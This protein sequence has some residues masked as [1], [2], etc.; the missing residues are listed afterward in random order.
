MDEEYDVIICGTGLKECILSG[1]LSVEGKKVLHVDRNRYYGGDGASLNITTLWQK[2]KPNEQPPKEYGANR[3]WNVDLVPKF[4]MASG[5][6]VK[7]LLHTGV[8]RYLEWK[9]V[10]GTY[11]YQYQEA[12]FFSN[13]KF[14]HKVPN[15]PQDALKSSLLGLMEKPRV[16]QFLN[17]VLGWNDND[18]KTWKGVDPQ[19]H[20]MAQVFDSYSLE[21]RT[22]TFLGHGVALYTNDMYLRAAA[23]PT[24]NKMKLYWQSLER[25]GGSPFIYPIY[26]LGG[27]PEGFSRLSA[28]HG[29]TYMLDTPVDG[30][31]FDEA[32]KVCGVKSGDQVAKCKGMVICDPTYV[33]SLPGKTQSIGQIIR[34]ICILGGPIPDTH[35]SNSVQIV[36]PGMELKRKNDVFIL[37]VSNAHQIS[38]PGKYV[39]IVSTVVETA[40][41]QKEIEQALRLLGKIENIFVTVSNQFVPS[42]DGS[43]DGIYVTS[44]FDPTSHFENAGKEVMDVWKKIF[45]TDLVLKEPKPD[46]EEM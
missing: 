26:G 22:R 27:L 2:F 11:V 7:I 25:Y 39:A 6:L 5:L 36:L 18:P 23:G 37:M 42:D 19:R 40:T 8:T 1:L 33:Q 28:I 15:T 31:V 44:S 10:E 35:E 12:G 16:G 9:S 20:S 41:P 32:G 46:E 24:I 30:F 38:A 45:G 34:A 3:D 17:F 13:E 29:G 4:I 21:E 14:I 43:K